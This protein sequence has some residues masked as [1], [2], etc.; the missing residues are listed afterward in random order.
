M[1]LFP[2]DT[3][4]FPDGVLDRLRTLDGSLEIGALTIIDEHGPKF[5]LPPAATPLDRSTVWSVIEMG[6]V[7]R[8]SRFDAVGGFDDTIGTGAP[9]PWQ[10]GEATDLLLRLRDAG[11][12]EDFTWLSSDCFLGGVADSRGLAPR[13]RRRKLR[14]YG[15]GLGRL[16]VRHA[17]PR[18]WIAAFVVGGILF[19]VRHGSQYSALDG[20]WVF[21]GRL[22]GVLGRVV[23]STPPAVSR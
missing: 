2:N 13:E 17:Y 21:L 9:S 5:E 22:E 15:R 11:L 23:G 4:W 12:T 7:V 10:A 19:G 16:V 1:L 6:L 3:T 20:A 14:G 8:R 18:A